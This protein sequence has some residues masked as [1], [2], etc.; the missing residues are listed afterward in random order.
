MASSFWAVAI[1]IVGAPGTVIAVSTGT[2]EMCVHSVPL[3]T[4]SSP[5]VPQLL[6]QII[7]PATGAS[8]KIRSA[9]DIR[10]GKNPLVVEVIS[11][12]AEAFGESVPIPTWENDENE[13]ARKRETKIN[14]NLL[15]L[16]IFLQK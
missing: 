16:L 14:C 13:I 6:H 2:P 11:K 15:I 5:L 8:I 10:G 3:Y 9:S 4:C 12:A 1:P 7:N